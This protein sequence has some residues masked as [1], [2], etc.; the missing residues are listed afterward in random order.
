MKRLLKNLKSQHLWIAVWVLFFGTF[1]VA[2][3]P[4]IYMLASGVRE[5]IFGIPGAIA[6]WIFDTLVLMIA[7]TF[8]Y[9]VEHVRGDLDECIDESLTEATE[10]KSSSEAI[11]I[12]GLETAR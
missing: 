9:Y 3:F 5:T 6:F 10:V 12:H 2:V 7:M 4:P 8:F 1:F 11:E